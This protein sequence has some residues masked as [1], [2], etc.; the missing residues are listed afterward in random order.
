MLARVQGVQGVA[1]SSGPDGEFLFTVTHDESLDMPAAV[2]SV[3]GFGVEI[4][5]SGP[6]I[7]S[8]RAVDPEVV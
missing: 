8:A 5:E 6:G 1:V 7:V 2:T 3:E 4:V